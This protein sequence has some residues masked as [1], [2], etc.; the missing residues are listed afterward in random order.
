[1]GTTTYIDN[2]NGGQKLI[3]S[4]SGNA[5]IGI[6]TGDATGVISFGR[7]G[8][9]TPGSNALV[10]SGDTVGVLNFNAGDGLTRISIARVSAEVAG[11]A[12]AGVVPGTLIFSTNDGT[13]LLETARIDPN[14][15]FLLNITS[16]LSNVYVDNT[17]VTPILQVEGNSGAA[18]TVCITRRIGAAANL[19]LQ[20]GVIGTPV[21]ID[22]L[23]GQI[24]F[25]GFDSTNFRNAAQITAEV[26]GTPGVDDMPGRLVFSTT[27]DGAATTTERMS[28]TN[29]GFIFPDLS[30][31]QAR[32]DIQGTL[33]GFKVISASTDATVRLEC[34]SASTA[35]RYGIAFSNPNGIVG[36]IST[37]GTATAYNIASDYRLKENVLAITDGIT[38]LQQLKPSRFNFIADPDTVVDGFIAHE[39]QEVVPGCATGTKDEVDADGNPVHQGIDQSK[40]VPL[41]TAALQEAVTR[42]ETLEAKVAA[43]EAS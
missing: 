24:N 16:A 20:R 40:L 26:D 21:A 41:L 8:D 6:A 35:T 14:G 3:I 2:W 13:G 31:R 7:S 36:S 23:V 34:F 37:N 43:L 15:R 38:R 39:A 11:V 18:S 12:S 28:I 30:S 29:E 19:I 25:N 4:G 33:P 9:S 10:T 1:V 22:D 27:A 17:Q 32:A 5:G 42:V